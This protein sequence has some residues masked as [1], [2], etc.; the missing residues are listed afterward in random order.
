MILFMITAYIALGS[1]M[2]DRLNYLEKVLSCF[3]SYPQLKMRKASSIYE[4]APWGK[5]DQPPFLNCVLEIDT[6]FTPQMLLE[7]LREIERQLGRERKEKWGPRTIDLDILLYGDEIIN[8]PDLTIPHPRMSQR[9]FVMIPLIEIAPELI[10]PVFKKTMKQLADVLPK[11][12]MPVLGQ[13]KYSGSKNKK[14]N[15]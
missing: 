7:T 14:G 2:G 15:A 1:N 12:N 6:S 3:E 9:A 11:E 5:T 4:T 10:H 13:L 8:T